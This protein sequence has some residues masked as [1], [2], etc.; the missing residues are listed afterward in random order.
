MKAARLAAVFLTILALS[1]CA[2]LGVQRRDRPP[3]FKPG[4]DDL[5]RAAWRAV[6]D[7]RTWAPAAGAALFAADRLDRRVSR[8]AREKT[9][10]FGSE[11]SAGKT[12]DLLAATAEASALVLTLA[13]PSG[14]TETGRLILT[15]AGELG[16][17]AA[18]MGV[19]HLATSGLKGWTDRLR[20]DASDR[21]SFPSG[22]SSEAAAAANWGR[23]HAETLDVPVGVRTAAV[24]GL[25][26][27][28]AGTAWARVEAGKHY[29]SDVLAGAAL[30]NFVASFFY[31]LFHAGRR[32]GHAVPAVIPSAGGPS[33][34]AVVR[35]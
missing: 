30:G 21:L 19:N 25:A 9:P 20:P 14:Q 2:S 35:F 1:A 22:H 27:L 5:G 8:W 29:P 16:L 26:L 12:S 3:S 23:L 7:P 28:E 4:L 31:H 17:E 24:S 32:E 13:S 11:E 15:K 34:G 10:V 6:S 18:A 33:L